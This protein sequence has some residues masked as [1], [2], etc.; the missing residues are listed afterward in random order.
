MNQN[1]SR[2]VSRSMGSR[3]VIGALHGTRK[4]PSA[5]PTQPMIRGS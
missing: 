2:A 5:Y 4:C 1:C 3:S